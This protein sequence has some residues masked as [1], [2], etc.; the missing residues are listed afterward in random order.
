MRAAIVVGCGLAVV[1]LLRVLAAFVS[2]YRHTATASGF[3]KAGVRFSNSRRLVT[4]KDAIRSKG[5]M[6]ANE[7]IAAG[8]TLGTVLTLPVYAS[9]ER[10]RAATPFDVKRQMRARGR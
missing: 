2:D 4:M 8:M 7:K 9:W 1:F 5:S 6:G 3:S 10:G